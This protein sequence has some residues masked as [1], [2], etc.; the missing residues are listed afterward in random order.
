VKSIQFSF[1]IGI[2]I[3]N[4][5]LLG[6]HF[7][8]AMRYSQEV[9]SQISLKSKVPRFS[10]EFSSISTHRKFLEF[11]FKFQFESGQVSIREG[12]PYLKLFLSI[13]FSNFWSKGTPLFRSVK[14]WAN[15][16]PFE[17]NLIRIESV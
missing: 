3:S 13:F 15:L 4:S 12:V 1:S 5:L 6:I 16:N 17:I 7:F 2:Q 14:L 11:S 8:L 10:S 9:A